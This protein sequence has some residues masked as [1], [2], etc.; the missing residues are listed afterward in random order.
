MAG[1][2]TDTSASTMMV[3]YFGDGHKRPLSGWGAGEQPKVP[4]P[5]AEECCSDENTKLFWEIDIESL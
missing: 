2:A 1:W 5:Q 3:S 4:L